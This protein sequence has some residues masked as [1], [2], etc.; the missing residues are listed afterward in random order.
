MVYK[1][2]R[3]FKKIYFLKKNVPYMPSNMI[4]FQFHI[5][6]QLAGAVEYTDCTSAEG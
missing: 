5:I 1:M 4:I 3:N 2:Q 6:A